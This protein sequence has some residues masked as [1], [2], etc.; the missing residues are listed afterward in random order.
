MNDKSKKTTHSHVWGEYSCRLC[1]I[2]KMESE[3]T[4]DC[5]ADPQTTGD[6]AEMRKKYPDLEH[7]P[8]VILTTT[9]P[10]ADFIRRIQNMATGWR[11][12]G[13]I[14]PTG[15]LCEIEAMCR[16]QDRAGAD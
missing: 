10:E 4:A 2:A 11:L 16:E 9:K 8:T 5:P 15:A 14:S 3:M 6:D 7:I 12:E 13:I 1:G